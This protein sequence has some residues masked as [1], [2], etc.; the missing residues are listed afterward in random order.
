MIGQIEAEQ[1]PLISYYL[2]QIPAPR[3]WQPNNPV[4]L[5]EGDSVKPTQR[6]GADGTLDCPLYITE[7]NNPFE[8]GDDFGGLNEAISEVVVTKTCVKQPWN[9]FM[10]Q[11]QAQ[12]FST[13]SQSNLHENQGH[14]ATSFITDNYEINVNNPDLSLKAGKGGIAQGGD[15]YSGSSLLTPQANVLLKKAIETQLINKHKIFTDIESISSANFEG[16][17]S[18]NNPVYSMTCAYEQLSSNNILA[19]SLNGFNQA[20]LMRK[21]TLELPIDDPLGFDQYLAFTRDGVLSAMG[22]DTKNAPSPRNAFNPIRSGCLKLLQLQLVDTFGQVK[23]LNTDNIDTTYKMTSPASKHL[24]KLPPRLAQ[25]ARLNFRWLD[26]GKTSDDMNSHAGTS[27]L[28]GWLLN[29]HFDQ[30][31]M[32]YDRDGKALG[33]FKA[34]RWHQAIDSDRPVATIEQIDNPHLR[35]VASYIE[36]SLA[37]DDTFLTHFI[38]TTENSLAHIQTEKDSGITGPALLIGRPMALVRASLNLEL[39]GGPAVNQDWNVFRADM[40]KN[41]RTSDKFTGVQFPVRLGEHG[42]LNDGL[43]GY[44]VEKKAADG[45][46]TFATQRCDWQ[47]N[48]DH[49]SHPLFY[50]PQS[51]YRDDHNIE[52]QFDNLEDGPINFFQSLDDPAQTVTLLMDVQGCIHA[53]VGILPNK[54]INIPA[55]HYTQALKNIEVSFLHAPLLTTKDKIQL[56]LRPVP[57]Y[58]WSWVEQVKNQQ[59]EISWDERFVA[60]RIAKDLFI[61]QYQ[62]STGDRLG[63]S[64]WQYLHSDDVNWLASVDDNDNDDGVA[65]LNQAKLISKEHR[66]LL[67]GQAFTPFFNGRESLVETLLKQLSVGIDQAVTEAAVMAPQEI[68]EG[69][70]KLRRR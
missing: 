52:S 34:Q 54:T 32:F 5:L 47:G 61:E 25:P 1:D 39:C 65:D 69:W 19:Q 62:L 22:G 40:A 44:W 7:Q 8:S 35:R 51:D 31:V 10:L 43:V 15:I 18:F 55:E 27:P 36:S 57:D 33:Y 24:I 67:T 29:N 17:A 42:Q 12:L 21:Q 11:W 49:S 28:C 66:V 59:G 56:A 53:T 58:A 20:L 38:G 9:P 16:D 14:Y 70:L 6:H 2:E 26:G 41:S 60:R 64:M 3:Y 48:I 45:S 13:V 30:S 4:V 63:Y 37:H 50:A 68:K 46:L 23:S